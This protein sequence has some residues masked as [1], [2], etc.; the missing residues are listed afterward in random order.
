VVGPTTKCL[1]AAGLN[2]SFSVLGGIERT[3]AR[4]TGRGGSSYST[5][6]LD[7]YDNAARSDAGEVGREECFER[8]EYFLRRV[9]PAPTGGRVIQTPLGIFHSYT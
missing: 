4:A 5:F 2:Y 6:V 8:I 7:E 9:V 3:D 1:T